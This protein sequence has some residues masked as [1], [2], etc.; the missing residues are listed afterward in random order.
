MIIA[1]IIILFILQLLMFFFIVLL[2]LKVARFNQLEEKQKRLMREMDTT[3]STYLI[4]MQEENNRF[5]EELTKTPKAPV[6]PTAHKH[7]KTP[8]V[9]IVES[10]EVT[11]PKV[12]EKPRMVVPKTKAAKAYQQQEVKAPVIKPQTVEEQAVALA[13][14]GLSTEAI[15]KQLQKGKTEIELLLKFRT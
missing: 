15:A 10:T 1:S 9:D 7:T 14:Q 8:T 2:Q 11:L 13:A 3:I 4:Q 5:I 12:Q 6:Q